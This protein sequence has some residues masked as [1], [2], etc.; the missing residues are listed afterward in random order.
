MIYLILAIITIIWLIFASLTDLKTTEIPDWLSFSLIAI[1]SFVIIADSIKTSSFTPL[2][3]A[4]GSFLAAVVI[5]LGL[6]FS[7]QWGGGDAKLLMALGIVFSQYPKELLTYFNPNLDFPFFLIF[8]IN[9][10]LAGVIY[11]LVFGLILTIKNFKDFKPV[12]QKQLKKTLKLRFVLVV[13]SILTLV[14]GLFT[15]IDIAVLT[16]MALFIIFIFTYLLAYT[17][18][19]EKSCMITNIAPNKLQEGDWIL[20]DIKLNKKIIYSKKSLGVSREQINNLIKNNIKQ[21]KIKKGIPF[22]PSFLF[23]AILSFTL[24]NVL[25]LVLIYFI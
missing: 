25:T 15:D 20:E 21:V 3:W 11:S 8:L 9:T 14:I 1:A 4:I 12:F 16:I 10:L 7:K 2:I 24:G 18:S 13:S 23:G 19:I 22:V 5:S 17:K 6:Y